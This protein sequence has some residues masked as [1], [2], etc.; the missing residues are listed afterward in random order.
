MGSGVTATFVAG[1]GVASATGVTGGLVLGTTTMG[2]SG[3]TCTVCVGTGVTVSAGTEVVVVV[4]VR[5][6]M[7][8]P[9]FSVGSVRLFAARCCVARLF[10]LILDSAAG[11]E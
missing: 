5:G 6:E 2:G 3:W 11:V 1:G 9:E 4:V 8:V 10:G 7:C